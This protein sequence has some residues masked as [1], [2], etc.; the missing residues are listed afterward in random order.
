[1]GVW[2]I[3]NNPVTFRDW[4]GLSNYDGDGSDDS[5]ITGSD[6]SDSGEESSFSMSNSEIAE[7]VF[8]EISFDVDGNAIC[9]NDY[10]DPFAAISFAFQASGKVVAYGVKTGLKDAISGIFLSISFSGSNPKAVSALSTTHSLVNFPGTIDDIVNLSKEI[11]S[12]RDETFG[13]NCTK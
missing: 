1:M 10:N 13:R 6:D 8:G 7:A 4:L 9:V 11:E 12:L 2:W 3:T 5:A